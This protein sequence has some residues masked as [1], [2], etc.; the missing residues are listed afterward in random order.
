MYRINSLIK[1]VVIVCINRII[2]TGRGCF[3]CVNVVLDIK[4]KTKAKK[5]NSDR[6]TAA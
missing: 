1:P 4:T 2:P 3:I 6:A 5:L